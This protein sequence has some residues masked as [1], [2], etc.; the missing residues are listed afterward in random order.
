M[1]KDRPVGRYLPGSLAAFGDPLGRNIT[2]FGVEQTAFGGADDY[3]TILGYPVD[4]SFDQCEAKYRRQDVAKVEIIAKSNAI[5]KDALRLPFVPEAAASENAQET[6]L[7]EW[8]SLTKRVCLCE[9]LR[10]R[11][12][13]VR[14]A[15]GVL[16]IEGDCLGAEQSP[17]QP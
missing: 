15:Q 11:R 3:Y 16:E 4:V 1:S 7:A 5:W 12:L 17:G 2:Y 13:C 8:E 10:I 9:R 14:I 6:F